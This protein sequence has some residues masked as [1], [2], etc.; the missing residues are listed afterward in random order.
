MPG[1][2]RSASSPVKKPHPWWWALVTLVWLASGAGIAWGSLDA[3]EFK[4]DRNSMSFLT[5]IA[6]LGLYAAIRAFRRSRLDYLVLAPG[7][8]EVY[9]FSDA[10]DS[11]GKEGDAALTER[12]TWLFRSELAEVRLRSASALP[13]AGQVFGFL[14]VTEKI[15]RNP[16]VAS[17]I[18]NL[19]T[20]AFVSHAYEVRGQIF[21]STGT[22][23]CGLTV[24]VTAL[25]GAESRPVRVEAD[26][27]EE[28]AR[29]A[30]LS[31]TAF[32]MPNTKICRHQQPWRSWQ[33]LDIPAGL[34]IVHQEAQK[35][36]SARRYDEALKKYYEAVEMD[37]SNDCLL[38]SIGGLQEKMG[39]HLDALFTYYGIVRPFLYPLSGMKKSRKECWRPEVVIARYR[40]VCLLGQG[41][42]LARQWRHQQ[43]VGEYPP[44]IRD[45][46]RSLLRVR[47][48]SQIINRY[49]K[50]FGC[51][52]KFDGSYAPVRFKPVSD[53]SNLLSHLDGLTGGDPEH[54][55]GEEPENRRFLDTVH[56]LD[57]KDVMVLQELFQFIAECEAKGMLL[58]YSRVHVW[59][60]RS[61]DLHLTPGVLRTLLEWVYIR[62]MHT[63]WQC[64]RIGKG[65]DG[66]WPPELL[67]KCLERVI[68]KAFRCRWIWH[69]KLFIE[70]YNAACAL[71]IPLLP[72][73]AS[74]LGDS[75]ADAFSSPRT[76][77]RVRQT[78][79]HLVQ[80]AVRHLEQARLDTDSGYLA[81]VHHWLISEDCDLVGL[82]SRGQFIEWVNEQFPSM[83]PY[84]LL[85]DNVQPLAATHY[86]TELVRLYSEVQA[87][88]WAAV[89]SEISVERSTYD[90]VRDT[91]RDACEAWE[92]LKRGVVNCRH[93]QSRLGLLEAVVKATEKAPGYPLVEN[94]PFY[95]KM[96]ESNLLPIRDAT[97][98][99]ARSRMRERVM[100][101]QEL[102]DVMFRDEI[103]GPFHRCDTGRGSDGILSV[104]DAVKEIETVADAGLQRNR[105]TYGDAE[106]V[107]T[108]AF[109]MADGWRTNARRFEGL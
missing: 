52:P 94:D 74:A 29:K 27:W 105:V 3:Y 25:T 96:L 68:K 73:T 98:D 100:A 87:R 41:E 88:T 63:R 47:I 80:D 102:R 10:R 13:G 99:A 65:S 72:D 22:G 107:R 39:L 30:A 101:L 57:G 86:M 70:H 55:M 60:W 20:A 21:D 67:P 12:V 37:P 85:P 71:S 75:S 104:K 51:P 26:T 58:T 24:Q 33:N 92:Q 91:A 40:Y 31:A 109:R 84:V 77:C 32:V 54:A 49:R 46:E 34:F 53:P 2:Q 28:A 108:A 90:D 7:P 56:T 62:K 93:W 8:I 106:T 42:V 48:A 69:E 14:E 16:G 9:N 4:I 44:S 83:D 89:G 103:E 23:K 81:T 15:A 61:R 36:E 45:S 50:K 95:R 43:S 38:L 5:V 79:D 35:L 76:D 66:S 6:L 19:F 18:S 11:Q 64:G 59:R 97:E 82:R 17:A 1:L 78:K